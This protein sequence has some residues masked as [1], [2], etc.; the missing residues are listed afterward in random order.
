M[1]LPRSFSPTHAAARRLGVLA[2]VPR[3]RMAAGD[4]SWFSQFIKHNASIIGGVVGTVLAPGLGTVLGAG[5]G[6]AISGGLSGGSTKLATLPSMNP[7]PIMQY[8]PTATGG[9][10]KAS[11]MTAGLAPL[12][13]GWGGPVTMDPFTSGGPMSGNEPT[14]PNN[15]PPTAGVMAFGHSRAISISATNGIRPRGYHLNRGGY[16]ST[17]I[18]TM[19]IRVGHWHAAQT[20]WIPNRRRNPLNPRALHRSMSRLISARHAVKKLGL[21]SVPRHARRRALVVPKGSSVKL[22]KA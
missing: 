3:G 1:P 15:P 8:R 16:Y 17:V 5:L 14:D 10:G 2:G 21:L 9:M 20:M 22:L 19:G 11:G 6:K 18:D 4:P 13:P 7:N 12:P